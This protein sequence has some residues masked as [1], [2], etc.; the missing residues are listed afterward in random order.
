MAR[1]RSRKSRSRKIVTGIA[2]AAMGGLAVW[3]YWGDP[4]IVPELGNEPITLT[5]NLSEDKT[6]R[7]QAFKDPEKIAA[8]GTLSPGQ[9]SHHRTP[10]ATTD[11]QVPPL[12]TASS[13]GSLAGGTQ[14]LTAIKRPVPPTQPS[15]APQGVTATADFKAG[16][17][18]IQ[19][20]DLV[21][22]RTLLNRSLHA[23]LRPQ[24][25]QVARREL[26]K[27]ANQTLFSRATEKEDALV[28]AYTVRLGDTLGKIAKRFHVSE[29][30]LADINKI[31]NKN[32]IRAGMRL[33]VVHGP[34]H[35]SISKS[36]HLMHVYLQDIYVRTFR[37]ALGTNGGTPTGRWL[38]S[39]HQKN[40]GWTDPRTGKRWHPDDPKNPIGEYWIGLEGKE[41]EAVGALSYGIHGTIEP[42]TIGQDVSLGCVRLAPDD[43]AMVYRLLVPGK[44]HVTVSP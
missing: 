2:V 13:N 15:D 44:S 18:A 24:D 35:A 30:L 31:R 39:N 26:A 32:F 42:K 8:G 23:G 33:K 43:I 25:A 3:L 11:P 40:P 34:F 14:P 41:G 17:R 29:D 10:S 22:G 37:V 9:A 20:K 1:R 38:V 7:G 5:G 12:L 28:E 16:L 27:L 36:D 4:S 19:R 6:V 21:T